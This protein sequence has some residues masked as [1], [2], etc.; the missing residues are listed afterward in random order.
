MLF[1]TL[2]ARP[3]NFLQAVE[4]VDIDAEFS[5]RDYY[6]TGLNDVEVASNVRHWNSNLASLYPAA[7]TLRP[8]P[9]GMGLCLYSLS[10][11]SRRGTMTETP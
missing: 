9:G 8:E 1:P 4:G 3:A 6:T 10:A 2:R 11:N 5:S 7:S